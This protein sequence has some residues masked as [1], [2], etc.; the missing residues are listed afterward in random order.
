LNFSHRL[1]YGLIIGGVG[2]KSYIEMMEQEAQEA[3]V[4]G[5]ARVIVQDNGSIHRCKEVQQLWKKWESQGLYMFFLPT[6]CSEMNPIKLEW[7]HIKKDELSG[8]AFDDELDLAYAVIN[9]VQARGEK[10]NHST[11]RVKFNSNHQVKTLL[12]SGKF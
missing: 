8:Q 4:A 11:R 9:G 7:Q 3:L 2:R 1:T 6:Y 10:N 12:H 5:R